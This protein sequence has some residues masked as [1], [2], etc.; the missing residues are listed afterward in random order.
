[1][2]NKHLFLDFDGTLIDSRRRQYELFTELVG[3]DKFTFEKYWCLKRLGADQAKMLSEHY[4]YSEEQ[5]ASF[6]KAWMEEIESPCRL[7]LDELFPCVPSFL[8][9]AS[10][11]FELY[12]VT[13]RQHHD[14]LVDQMRR[15]EIWHN[16][17]GIL[18]TAQ[19]VSKADLVRNT[20]EVGAG[21][22]FVGDTGEDILAGQ[23][24]GIIAVGVASGVMSVDR[25]KKYS[26]DLLVNS[27]SELLPTILHAKRIS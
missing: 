16:F 12:L 9:A 10:R 27:V 18:N 3:E 15:L 21:D 2:T 5:R 4:G 11:Y 7:D 14:R 23:N 22:I 6:K 8:D 20:V 17:T 1:M 26:P 19:R 24:L 13:A 25:L